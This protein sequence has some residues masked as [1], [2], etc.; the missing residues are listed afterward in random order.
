VN[1]RTQDLLR[2]FLK[3]INMPLLNDLLTRKPSF[4]GNAYNYIDVCKGVTRLF[5]FVVVVIPAIGYTVSP[6]Q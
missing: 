6:K 1:V 5:V 4:E 3:H 2:S